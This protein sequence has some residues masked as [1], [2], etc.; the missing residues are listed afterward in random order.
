MPTVKSD[1]IYVCG[2]AENGK[3]ENKQWET[4]RFPQWFDLLPKIT[5]AKGK[6]HIKTKMW[7]LRIFIVSCQFFA[8]Y[9]LC[10]S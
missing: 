3:G 6:K 7:T 8:I 5:I 4:L 10:V 2:S 9:A 1:S